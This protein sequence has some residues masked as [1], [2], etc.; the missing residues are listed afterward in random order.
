MPFEEIYEAAKAQNTIRR[1]M[2]RLEGDVVEY[3]NKELRRWQRQAVLEFGL[4]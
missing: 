1:Q 2:V 4:D 3:L